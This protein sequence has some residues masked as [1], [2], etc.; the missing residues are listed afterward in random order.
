MKSKIIQIAKENKI[1][2]IG[3]CLMEDY[4][5]REREQRGVF[6]KNTP[7]NFEPKTAIV[8]AF[9]YYVNHKPGN[10]SRY[11]WGKDYH[12]VAKE[13]MKPITELLQREGWQAESY[14][15]VGSLNERLLAKL[16]G[17]AFIG[18][19]QM[20]ISTR[21]GSYFF[22]GYIL[23]DCQI[24]PDC[25]NTQECLGCGKC[26]DVCPLGAISDEGFSQERCLSYITQK[27]GDL[28]DAEAEVL[29]NNG[30]VWGCDNCQSVCPHN[31]NVEETEIDEFKNNLITNLQIEDMSNKEFARMFGQRA[32]A[33]RGK[34]VLLRNQKCIYNRKEKLF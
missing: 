7:L 6:S 18:R 2:D 21:L 33:W 29:A 13:K 27:K 16:S 10:V 28:T 3:F 24:E 20:A 5:K 26:M 8:F 23:T 11:A 25:E 9:G 1:S 4:F 14:A 30:M 34:G 12:V 19:N 32:F 17:L 15:D 31:E 22:I